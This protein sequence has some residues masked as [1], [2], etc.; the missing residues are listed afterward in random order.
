MTAFWWRHDSN[1]NPNRTLTLAAAWLLRGCGVA[2][3]WLRRDCGVAAAWLRCGCGMAAAWLRRGCGVAAAFPR[4]VS[5]LTGAAPVVTRV[6]LSLRTKKASHSMTYSFG[7]EAEE[8]NA[9][10]AS[11]CQI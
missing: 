1:S 11:T 10:S 6:K 3:A 2:A 9:H 8:G 5:L 4:R 7:S